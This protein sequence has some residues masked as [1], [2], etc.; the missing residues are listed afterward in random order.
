MSDTVTKDRMYAIL[1]K[2]QRQTPISSD[3]LKDLQ[4]RIDMLELRAADDPHHESHSHGNDHD[5]SHH[6]V[7]AF[8]L[9]EQA[10]SL[11]RK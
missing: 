9:E 2:L 8:S 6:G 1:Y 7:V 3:E 10:R 4:T 5:T 11:Q